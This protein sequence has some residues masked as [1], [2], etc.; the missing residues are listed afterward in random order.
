MV[1]L[2][3]IFT[4]FLLVFRL[5]NWRRLVNINLLQSIVLFGTTS[6]VLFITA[7]RFRLLAQLRKQDRRRYW[8]SRSIVFL[9]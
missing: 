1:G 2:H 6:V 7:G 4:V 3:H 9:V 8:R 5:F